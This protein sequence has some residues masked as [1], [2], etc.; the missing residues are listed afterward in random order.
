M[1]HPVFSLA[2]T[3][4]RV[5][6][7]GLWRGW[8]VCKPFLQ[9]C[10]P[11]SSAPRWANCLAYMPPCP[12][13][14]TRSPGHPH[15]KPKTCI[16]TVHISIG[17]PLSRPSYPPLRNALAWSG[18]ACPFLPCPKA[19]PTLI[20]PHTLIFCRAYLPAAA[21]A[22]GAAGAP[23]AGR[24]QLPD[25]RHLP[26]PAVPGGP[27]TPPDNRGVAGCPGGRAAGHYRGHASGQPRASAAGWGGGRGS[28]AGGEGGGHG[29]VMWR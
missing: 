15:S 19:R 7:G 8:W 22:A 21:G 29:E 3:F 13:P 1:A 4:L 14:I 5:C 12:A 16:G 6:Q 23:R 20:P 10:H 18:Q 28:W 24:R 2:P 9:P 11:H 25:A 27:G 17:S 26:R